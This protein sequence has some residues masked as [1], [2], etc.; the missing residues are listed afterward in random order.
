M[1]VSGG[2]P[3]TLHAGFTAEDSN[4]NPSAKPT[5]SSSNS[6]AKKR[7]NLAGT[8]DPDAEVIALSPKTLMAT[9]RF[10]CEI[11]NKGFQREQNLQLH[12]RGHNLPWKLKQRT[13][14]DLIRKKVYICPEKTC[15]HHDPARALGDL[16]G[17]KKHYSRKHGEKKWKCE[18]CTKKYAV[19]SDWKA[20]SKICGTRE[21]KC[22]CGTIFS[23]RDSFITH[24]A[25][26]DALAEESARF[27]TV[28]PSNLHFRS[29]AGSI[30]S[31]QS[32]LSHGFGSRG[33]GDIAGINQYSSIL[34]SDSGSVALS[35]NSLGAV[36]QQ[37]SRIPLWLN[38]ANP[39]ISNA[40]EMLP[41]SNLFG[42]PSSM[43]LPEMLQMGS[44]NSL[45]GSS[46]MGGYGGY[47]QF[48][49][50]SSG[51]AA[52]LNLSPLKEEVG[53]K[54]YVMET[55]STASYD[56]TR[57]TQMKPDMSATALLQKAAQLGS[58]TSEPS[59]MFGNAFGVMMSSPS[60]SSNTGFNVLIHQNQNQSQINDYD[61]QIPNLIPNLK[62]IPD[63]LIRGH[64][65]LM[66]PSTARTLTGMHHGGS[67]NST[68]HS[69]L[70]RDFLGVSG[71]AGGPFSPQE[72]VKLASMSSAMGL[73]HFNSNN[74]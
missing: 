35:G 48:P 65:S 66:G 16:T 51:L 10:I 23:R 20:H 33:I 3:F 56:C 34:R 70:T 59:S 2:D 73:T 62:P 54:G 50:A 36:Q 30:I 28:T 53:C 13:N 31:A 44:A 69:S 17:V 63:D 64:H 38:Q 45:F 27:S 25:F 9:N 18:K 19:Q 22:D 1:N 43:M 42:S 8:P 29:D 4:S 68:D 71:E 14:K 40:G 57:A 41:S 37:K 7:R 67:N 12:R 72:L 5:S 32:G 46:G 49:G 15:V 39:H 47:G 26:C 21:Y 11:C 6:G 58:K 24:R 74:H 52:N 61:H 55:P 60:N